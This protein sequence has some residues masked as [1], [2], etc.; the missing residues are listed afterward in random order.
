MHIEVESNPFSPRCTKILQHLFCLPLRW[1]HVL[2][3]STQKTFVPRKYFVCNRNQIICYSSLQ[4]TNQE[5]WNKLAKCYATSLPSMGFLF[6][7]LPYITVLDHW[8][9][10]ILF[11]LMRWRA[12]ICGLQVTCCWAF[13]ITSV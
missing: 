3:K 11:H 9:D 12:S 7:F 1:L 10:L 8:I 6:L 2:C 13:W 4:Q 5:E